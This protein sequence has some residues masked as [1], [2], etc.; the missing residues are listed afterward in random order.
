VEFYFFK[1]T[2]INLNLMPRHWQN[3]TE[4]LEAY[5]SNISHFRHTCQASIRHGA[6]LGIDN[7]VQRPSVS[8]SDEEPDAAALEW[9]PLGCGNYF[10][11]T[12][13]FLQ[14]NVHSE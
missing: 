1:I 4:I 8:R 6:T 5:V 14:Y 3:K 10:L 2:L 9:P 13:N 7:K 11:A 12:N